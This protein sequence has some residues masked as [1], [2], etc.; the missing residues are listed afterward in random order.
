MPSLRCCFF[1]RICYNGREDAAI[2][3]LSPFFSPA[4]GGQ[5]KKEVLP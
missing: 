1:Q 5:P 2:M 4:K 3:F